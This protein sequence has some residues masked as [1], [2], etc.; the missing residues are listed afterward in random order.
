MTDSTGFQ[1]HF[2][3]PEEIRKRLAGLPPTSSAGYGV[4]SGQVSGR[5]TIASM[6]TQ[7]R[8]PY[9]EYGIFMN[10]SV[11]YD[12]QSNYYGQ[13]LSYKVPGTGN[14]MA[15]Y[16]TWG[17]RDCDWVLNS[18]QPSGDFFEGATGLSQAQAVYGFNLPQGMPSDLTQSPSVNQPFS[19]TDCTLPTPPICR[20]QPQSQSQV[21]KILSTFPE[22]LS[23]MTPA[24]DPKNPFWNSHTRRMAMPT[25]PSN[26][27][28][29]GAKPS[30]SENGTPTPD[31]TFGYVRMATTVY[32]SPALP[33]AASSIHSSA[34]GNNT[35]YPVL[36]AIDEYRN[37]PVRLACNNT[38]IRK[39]SSNSRLNAL[40]SDCSPY[41]YEYSSGERSKTR[42]SAD[43]DETRCSAPTLMSGLPYRRVRHPE[44]NL[45]LRFD[46][47]ADAFSE[48]GRV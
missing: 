6:E 47:L 41:S 14:M 15:D 12:E 44:H 13:A 40:I 22:E 30:T 45:A 27:T 8:N 4:Y 38:V 17:L 23:C 2:D 35:L 18:Q 43:S 36:D 48:Y 3:T 7:S 33:P 20:S 32:T 11:E 24:T 19:E 39:K 16:S 1:V 46:L 28:S 34:T 31:L 29:P 21:P 26:Y 9:R 25:V 42:G 37:G 5:Q 10:G